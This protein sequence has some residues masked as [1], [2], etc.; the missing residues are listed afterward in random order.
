MRTRTLVLVFVAMLMPVSTS[1]AWPERPV[2]LIVGF[3][4][5]GTSDLIARLMAQEMSSGLGQPVVVENRTGAGG[6]VAFETAA[7][8]EPDGY[9]IVMAGM[10]FTL[11]PAIYLSLNWR[12][13]DFAPIILI[14]YTPMTI[15]VRPDYPARTLQDLVAIARGRSTPLLAA[16]SG[17]GTSSHV[18]NLLFQAAAGV[19]FENVAYTGGAAPF[20]D[21][22]AGRV[23]LMT[24]LAPETVSY[25]QSK[26]VRVLAITEHTAAPAYRGVPTMAE[27]GLPEAAMNTWFGLLA[28]HR[29]PRDAVAELH[30]VAAEALA[31]PE[32]S[33]RKA[34]MAL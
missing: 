1:A 32:V 15:I 5:G 28:P 24:F 34:L 8:A 30:L 7:R 13:E 31:R 23:D 22:M 26:R 27:A 14:G 33:Q 21:L 10:G 29:T 11:N 20:L 17:S 2:R 6:N 25:M 4:A 18:A 19:R 9:T 3:G 16:H 12:Q